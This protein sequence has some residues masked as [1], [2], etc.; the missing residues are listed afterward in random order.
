MS[1][2]SAPA[3]ADPE[4]QVGRSRPERPFFWHAFFLAMTTSFTEI[5]TVMPALVLAAGGGVVAVGALTAVMIGLPLVSQLLFAGFLTTRPRKRPYLLLGIHLRVA[6]LAGA[7]W[8]IAALGTDPRVIGVVFLAMTVFAM[9]GAF[10]GVSYTD[11]VGTLVP[12]GRRRS[13]FVRRQVLTTLGLLTSALV[14]RFLLGSTSFPQATSCSSPSRPGSSSWP[15]GGSGCCT[16]PAAPRRTGR[17]PACYARCAR[18]PGCSR[19]T[20]TC[21]RSSGW[22][23]S[24]PSG[25]PPFRCSPRWPTAAT[26]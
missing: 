22:P 18:R 2:T 3:T 26:S 19:P 5:N 1:T 12:S 8:G 7:A 21:G 10:A 4:A 16:S 23:T 17:G 25:S 20:P 6:A 15:P 14:V 13:F 9:S 11:L 24:P